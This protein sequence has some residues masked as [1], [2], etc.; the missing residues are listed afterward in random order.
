MEN[1]KNLPAPVLKTLE[2]LVAKAMKGRRDELGQVKAEFEVDQTVVLHA[3]GTVKV[4]KAT[5][6]ALCPQSA[7]PWALL[8]A[9]VMELNKERE[10]AGKAGIDIAKLVELAET[11]DPEL[12]KKAQEDADKHV[13]EIKEPTRKFKW[14]GVSVAGEIEVLAVGDHLADQAAGDE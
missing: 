3:K 14:G 9:A 6:D 12:A 10:A 4:S 5:P 8:T 7:K 1:L 2:K 11:V 13:R